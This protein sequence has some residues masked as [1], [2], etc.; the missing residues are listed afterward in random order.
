MGDDSVNLEV[1]AEPTYRSSTIVYMDD[2]EIKN[3]NANN[4]DK[5]TKPVLIY[6]TPP[7]LPF[8]L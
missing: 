8:L 6:Y 3:N 4:K 7:C 1:A 2:N 5:G